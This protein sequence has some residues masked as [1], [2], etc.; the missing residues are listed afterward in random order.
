M[1]LSLLQENL[2]KGIS[3]V[4]RFITPSPQLQ[5]LS[6]IKLEAK[7]GQLLLSATNLETG[8][9]LKLGA[10]VEKE[11]ALTIPAKVIQEFV[12]MLPKDKV[13]LEAKDASLKINCQGYHA[14]INGIGAAEFPQIPTLEN[15]KKAIVLKQESFLEAVNQVAFAAAVDETR[16]VLTASLIKKSG[17]EFLMVA[18]DGYRLSLKKTSFL[19]PRTTEN[20]GRKPVV[21]GLQKGKEGFDEI[22]VSGRVLIEIARLLENTEGEVLFSPSSEKNQIIFKGGNWEVVTRLIEGEFPPF[23][24]IIPQGQETKMSLETEELLQAVRTAAIFARDAS[25]IIRWQI[26]KPGQLLVSANAPQVGENLITLEGKLKGKAGKIAFNSRFLLDLLNTIKEEEV[27]FEMSGPTSPGVF[28]LPKD[29]TF[30][31]I[32]MPVR[33]QE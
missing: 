24:K 8:I 21:R 17:K 15:E 16:P 18:T 19:L 20:H 29:K 5:I 23:E 27:V 11:G 25:N 3:F 7:K 12:N 10:K 6:N 31:H 1:K 33:V 9:N 32:I 2:T 28:T 13:V 26:K 4:S 22:L 14:V 30:K